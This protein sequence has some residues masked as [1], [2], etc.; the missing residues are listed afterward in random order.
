MG[1]MRLKSEVCSSDGR[2]D[3]VVETTDRVYILEFKLDESAEAALAQIRQKKYYLSWRGLG[4]PVT[5][6]GVNFSSAT[7]NVSDWK[8]GTMEG[9]L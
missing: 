3:C 8:V 5:G 1:A 2:A 4:K 9:E 7:K 6:V